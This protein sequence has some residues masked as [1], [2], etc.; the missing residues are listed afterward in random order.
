[1][2]NKV[3]LTS[4]K[5]FRKIR[6]WNRNYYLQLNLYT[7]WTKCKNCTKWSYKVLLKWI[8]SNHE[9]QT[10]GFQLWRRVRCTVTSTTV[11]CAYVN[12]Q[13]RS[14]SSAAELMLAVM[15]P[16]IGTWVVIAYRTTWWL[17]SFAQETDFQ[18]PNR[19]L[20]TLPKAY[21]LLCYV[22][23]SCLYWANLN[24]SGQFVGTTMMVL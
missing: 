8:H 20:E 13:N 2:P 16:D 12:G 10:V 1:M 7:I 3:T 5:N 4:N 9:V 19:F 23:K 22:K 18:K 15:W 24:Y 14:H 17:P 11:S 6:T 21:A